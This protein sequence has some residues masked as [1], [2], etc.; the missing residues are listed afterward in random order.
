[1]ATSIF[2][3]ENTESA[4]QTIR[5]TMQVSTN[6]DGLPIVSFATNRGKGSGAQSM[7]VAQFDEYVTALE[8]IVAEGIPEASD[9]T[10]TA[11]ESLRQTIRSEDGVIS[12]RVRSGKGAKPAKVPASDLGEVATLLRSTVKAVGAAG[13]KLAKAAKSAE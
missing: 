12:F 5:Q 7:P 6:D 2:E 1:M 13:K 3:S 8:R 11:A 4:I 9:V 10:L